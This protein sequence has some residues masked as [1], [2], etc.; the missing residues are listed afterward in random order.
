MLLGAVRHSLPHA[1]AALRARAA[2]RSTVA[3]NASGVVVLNPVSSQA[4]TKSEATQRLRPTAA[5]ENH[6]VTLWWVAE[7]LVYGITV[8]VG[9]VN[10]LIVMTYNPG[11][12]MAVV[13]GE[14]LGLVASHPRAPWMRGCRDAATE[15]LVD[16]D[17]EAGG[18][19]C[20]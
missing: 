19:A 9:Y 11:L 5:A 2:G 12:M 8:L 3:A 20:H 6:H 10:M 15:P 4:A 1:R 14:M 16:V 13:I 7:V 18:S 17:L